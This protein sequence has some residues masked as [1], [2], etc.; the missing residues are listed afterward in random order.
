MLSNERLPWPQLMEITF[1]MLGIAPDIFWAMT[2]SEWLAAFSGWKKKYGIK[3]M[4][5]PEITRDD[6]R[7]L[8]GRFPD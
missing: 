4:L 5:T 2:P 8:M 3:E 7:E 1:A 6:L